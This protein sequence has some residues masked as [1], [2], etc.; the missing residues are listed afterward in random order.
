MILILTILI[1]TVFLEQ[2]VN[3]EELVVPVNFVKEYHHNINYNDSPGFEQSTNN[4]LISQRVIYS[5]TDNKINEYHITFDTNNV[6]YSNITYIEIPFLFSQ[7]LGKE[8]VHLDSDNLSMKDKNAV[9]CKEW[10]MNSDGN[11]QCIIYDSK[12]SSGNVKDHE[13]VYKNYAL[14]QFSFYIQLVYSDDTWNTCSLNSSSNI[15]CNVNGKIPKQLYFY[16]NFKTTETTTFLMAISRGFRCYSSA[17]QEQID[18]INN[19]DETLKQNHEYNNNASEDT[20]EQENEINNYEQ[21]EDSLRNSLNLDI[22]DSEITINPEANNFIWETINKLRGMS[23]K[24]VLLFTSVLS[25]G[26][27]KMILGR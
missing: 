8:E 26:L 4:A 5:T 12:I 6:N 24:I 20:S 19:V 15:V 18:A 9:Y 25:L 21:Q 13:Y 1:S 23:S 10:K 11:Y 3:A 27:M 7:P 2:K 16:I 22:E 14:D 17:T